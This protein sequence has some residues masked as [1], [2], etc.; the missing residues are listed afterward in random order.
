MKV[1]TSETSTPATCKVT[2]PRREGSEDGEVS[3]IL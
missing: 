3:V 2:V 1:A